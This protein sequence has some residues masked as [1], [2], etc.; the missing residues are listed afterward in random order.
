MTR[1]PVGTGCADP[2]ICIIEIQTE[3]Q[4]DANCRDQRPLR[5]LQDCHGYMI[6][7]VIKIELWEVV[8]Y[9]INPIGKV[10]QNN[11][12]ISIQFKR[13]FSS[14]FCKSTS[15]FRVLE[16]SEKWFLKP[17]LV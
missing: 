15:I 9:R 6:F 3:S 4:S 16:F 12:V 11:L 5:Q 17:A 2:N 13:V 10:Y 8:P 7:A 14:V 1:S